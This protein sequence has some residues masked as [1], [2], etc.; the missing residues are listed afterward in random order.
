MYTVHAGFNNTALPSWLGIDGSKIPGNWNLVYAEPDRVESVVGDG[1]IVLGRFVGTNIRG[2]YNY[3]LG[4]N[5]AGANV[6]GL[7]NTILGSGAGQNVTGHHNFVWGENAANGLG[8]ASKEFNSQP[9]HNVVMGN[10]AGTSL[11]GNTNYVF[12]VDSGDDLSGD[13]NF[14][15][16]KTAGQNLNG[17]HNVGLGEKALNNTVGSRNFA[18]GNEAGN[19]VTGDD[20]IA[21][22]LTT[23]KAVKGSN[24]IAMGKGAGSNLSDMTKF[25]I[26]IGEDAGVGVGYHKNADGTLTKSTQYLN[27]NEHNIALGIRAG[28]YVTGE[29]NFAVG[30]HSGYNMTG[31]EN[32]TMGFYAGQDVSGKSNYI[33]GA[34]AGDNVAGDHNVILGH[35]AGTSIAGSRNIA[36]GENA[37]DDTDNTVNDAISLGTKASATKEKVVAIGVE[38]K[39]SELNTLAIGNKAQANVAQS[40]A[41]GDNSI[42]TA[43]LT[44]KSAGSTTYNSQPITT[45]N[46]DVLQLNF[47]G[48]TPIGVI[49]VG[50][51]DTPRRVQNVAAGLI[52]A[53]ST[54]AVNG[55]QLF[56]VA[57]NFQSVAAGA[58]Q[59]T[60]VEAGKQINITNDVDT[61]TNTITYTVNGLDTQL[62]STDGSVNISG[63]T[64]DGSGVRRYD[65]SVAAGNTYNVTGTG[66]ISVSDSVVNGGKTF[67]ISAD[68]SQIQGKS[69]EITGNGL[70][71]EKSVDAQG[72]TTYALDAAAIVAADSSLIVS[73]GEVTQTDKGSTIS[74]YTVKVNTDVIATNQSVDNKISIVDNRINHVDNRIT[75]V[76]NRITNVDNRVTNLDSKVVKLDHRVN[77]LENV[78]TDLSD[79]VR[80][81]A[82]QGAAL[83]ALKPLQYDPLEP[84]QILAGYGYYRGTS[85]IALGLARYKNESTLIHAG[86]SWAGHDSHVMANAGITWKYGHKDKE[87]DIRDIYR[88]GPVSA[89]YVLQDKLSLLETQH[90]EQETTIRLQSEKINAQQAEIDELKGQ[91]QA[92]MSKIGV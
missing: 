88:Q 39:A 23:G 16:G 1:N 64:V 89:S 47:A 84:N 62:V 12:G 30:V 72:N 35:E 58:A 63:G 54:D 60:K 6:T 57:Q 20:N 70:G 21:I 56:A 19:N 83:S 37:G 18:A 40:V 31:N 80:Y 8:D 44:L 2:S 5:G 36:I 87:K 91:L 13:S 34:E 50:A 68:A 78:V 14:I 22:G 67:T 9:H 42:T 65:L 25:N 33:I 48:G 32:I 75:D 66:I 4:N 49:S 55:S 45:L 86:V 53:T 52:S 92:I 74:D 59:K 11:K 38:A 24:N 7:N 46:G 29:D 90:I 28:Q 76:D 77:N 61:T 43:A 73:G 26:A 69:T 82:A 15:L 51:A 81:S 79:E 85:A 41:L 3:I 71:I 17:N 10:G 27:A